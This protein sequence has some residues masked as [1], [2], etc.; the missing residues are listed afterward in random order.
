MKTHFCLVIPSYNQAQFIEE[1]ITSILTQSG[2]FKVSVI[3]RDGQSTDQ[4]VSVVKRFTHQIEWVSEP[5]QG[6]T[7]AINQG[8]A[9]FQ[10]KLGTKSASEQIIFAYLNSDDYY[11]PGALQTVA[12]AFTLYPE[13]Q[14]LVGDAQIVDVRGQEIQRWVRQYKKLWR[15]FLSW[16]LL[17]I[18]NPIPQPAT[19]I[20]WSA[21]QAVGDFS[22]ELRYVMD[23]DYWLRL[24]QRFGRPV[25]LDQALAAFRIHGQSKGGSQ[26]EKQFQE[27]LH[28]AQHYT[29]QPLFLFLHQLHT[30]LIVWIY[31]HIK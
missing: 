9:F 25:V 1:T 26:F 14:W 11:L 3:V 16:P 2:D 23:Y 29:Q 8:L 21:V 18:L 13:A 24:Y 20:R 5:D 4:T 10:Q 30:W 22:T 28:V 7:D 19:F 31:T 15:W 17:L 27:Q 12:K 6:Q